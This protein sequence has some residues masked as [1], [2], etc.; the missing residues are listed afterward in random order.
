MSE[1]ALIVNTIAKNSDIWPMFFGQLA[2]N[3]PSQF[4]ANKYVFLDEK[5]ELI[6]EDYTASIFSMRDKY[7]DQFLSCIDTVKEPYCIYISEDYVLYDKIQADLISG[8]KSVLEKEPDISFVRLMRGGAYDLDWPR[9]KHYSDLHEISNFVP[10]FYSNQTS[11]WR[12]SDLKKIHKEGPN[13]HIAGLKMEEQFE[14]AATKTCQELGIRGLY[15]YHD[16]QKRGI[17]HYDST[18]FPYIATALVKGKWNLSEYPSELSSLLEC[19]QID[20]SIRGAV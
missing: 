8:Y 3:I 4:F 5:E 11:L 12:T 18:V 6:P 19:Y 9:Y 20:S 2:V 16:E 10:Y 1:V 13:L 17:Y 7:R 14:P 15:C